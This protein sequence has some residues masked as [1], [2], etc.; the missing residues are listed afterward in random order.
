MLRIF[1]KNNDLSCN[2]YIKNVKGKTILSNLKTNNNNSRNVIINRNK[3]VSYLSYNDFLIIT[4]TFYKFTNL[5]KNYKSPQKIIDLKTSFVFY[6]KILSHMQSCDFC[7]TNDIDTFFSSCKEIKNILYPYGE[8]FTYEIYSNLASVDLNYWCNKECI[9]IHCD[10]NHCDNNH[11]DN[12]PD[13]LSKYYYNEPSDTSPNDSFKQQP[14]SVSSYNSS[15]NSSY[16]SLNN[17]SYHSSNNS[18]YH[19]SSISS[20]DSSSNHLT[21]NNYLDNKHLSNNYPSN[22][23][24]SNNYS[25]N[26]NSSYNSSSI[27]S[28]DSFN[29]HL[30]PHS[31]SISSKDLQNNHLSSHSSSISSNNHLSN[32]NSS[33]ISSKD[34][35]NNHLSNNH[36][37]SHSSSIS[38]NTSSM[39][40]N[41]CNAVNNSSYYSSSI[42][43]ND[44]SSI[45]SNDSS[46]ISSCHPENPPM[47]EENL[48]MYQE[49]ILELHPINSIKSSNESKKYYFHS[50]IVNKVHFLKNNQENIIINE[51]PNIRHE[52]LENT[53]FINKN[54]FNLFIAEL[55]NSKEYT[56]N[57]K[58]SV[59]DFETENKHYNIYNFV[60][61]YLNFEEF[62]NI[63]FNSKTNYFNISDVISEKIKLSNQYFKNINNITE[64]F[65]L[66]NSV[67]KIY[68]EK[69]N[70]NEMDANTLIEIE[71]ET[72]DFFSLYD[73]NY[74]TNSLTLDDILYIINKNNIESTCD[75]KIKIKVYYKSKKTDIPCIMYFNYI[76]RASEN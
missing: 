62:K 24:P 22:N 57:E 61:V 2:D 53:L 11:C 72:T 35:S 55:T 70:Y 15:N 65:V 31:S 44:S 3:I 7:K 75:I 49:N 30:S 21:D 4:Q 46:N 14:V 6:N 58:I 43:S 5:K 68:I 64:S 1:S 25:N 71:K 34:S 66:S 52:I 67:K 37:S 13:D 76:L 74:I 60:P 32:N 38:S 17:S 56:F 48:A 41:N 10:N 18:S 29:N 16:H 63:F 27:S 33:S 42:S 45:S 20:K 40:Q 54:T 23:Y 69:N 50:P 73:F 26:N 59:N 19:S 51:T 8:Y 9:N 39:P 36:L 28:K 12:N 47:Y